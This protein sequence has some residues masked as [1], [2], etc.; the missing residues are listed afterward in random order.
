MPIFCSTVSV[1]LDV[2]A[3]DDLRVPASAVSPSERQAIVDRIPGFVV[4]LLVRRVGG[5]G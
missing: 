3:A 2:A 1:A 4:E 5:A